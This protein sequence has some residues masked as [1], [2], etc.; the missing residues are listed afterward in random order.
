MQFPAQLSC[1]GLDRLSSFALRELREQAMFFSACTAG[2]IN[3]PERDMY[4]KSNAQLAAYLEANPDLTY[5]HID[6]SPGLTRLPK[7]PA[8]LEILA[9]V[10]CPHFL[11]C[12]LNCG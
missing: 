4:F 8:S 11:K 2:L 3:S 12:S 1:A 6:N 5:L 7:L 10:N 9:L